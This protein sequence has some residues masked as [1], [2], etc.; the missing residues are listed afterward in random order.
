MIWTIAL[1]AALVVVAY[2]VFALLF[3]WFKYGATL[4]LVWL[5]L[6]IYLVGNGFILLI[7]LAA[8]VALP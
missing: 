2:F 8:F 6:P 7:A 3:H 4:P 5:A 1:G